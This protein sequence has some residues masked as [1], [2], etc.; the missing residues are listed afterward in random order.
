MIYLYSVSDCHNIMFEIDSIYH[1]LYTDSIIEDCAQDYHDNKEGNRSKWPLN[2]T[3][4]NS[5]MD[6]LCSANVELEYSPIFY[7]G[8]VSN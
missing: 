5:K 2:F 3:V 8:N 7:V 6:E 4:Y 1:E